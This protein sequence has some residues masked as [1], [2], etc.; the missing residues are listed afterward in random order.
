MGNS[1]LGGI[2]LRRR[3]FGSRGTRTSGICNDLRE[4][5]NILHKNLF[6]CVIASEEGESE[7]VSSGIGDLAR[8]MS[9]IRLRFQ[10]DQ[11]GL[12]WNANDPWVLV[13]REF[14]EGKELRDKSKK[15]VERENTLY[16]NAFDLVPESP[17]DWI[18]YDPDMTNSPRPYGPRFNTDD[19]AEFY[20]ERYSQLG[21]AQTASTRTETRWTKSVKQQDG[22][23]ESSVPNS[24]STAEESEAAVPY[25]SERALKFLH[26]TAVMLKEGGNAALEAGSAME[27]A[28]RYDGAIKYCAVALL[29]HPNANQDFLQQTERKWCPI[30]KVLVTTRLN[31]CLVLSNFDLRGA[32]EQAIL[33]LKELAPFCTKPGKVL[34]GKKLSVV[35]T[36]NEP[37]STYNEAKELQAKAYFRHGSVDLK[38][39]DYE[40]AVDEF[41]E[42][43]KCTKEL[44]K[45]PDRVLL[46]RLAEAKREKSRKGKRQKKKFKRMLATEAWGDD[47]DDSS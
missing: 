4:L 5:P 39:G 43:I 15:A 8:R 26:D 14:Y 28:R 46:R 17:S 10:A 38:K 20:W 18:P 27:A 32:R 7:P 44:S 40:E 36:E 22:N 29:V 16:G 11:R 34:S 31:L 35:H 41:E 21:S 3:M 23:G 19:Y 33:A 47:R 42:S 13:S 6:S 9:T 1:I 2:L 24:D 45:E 30:R 25:D 12:V 37:I